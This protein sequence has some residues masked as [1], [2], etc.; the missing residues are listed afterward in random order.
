VGF[1]ESIHEKG[2]IPRDLRIP[3]IIERDGKLFIIDFG[4]A[5]YLNDEENDDPNDHP[6]KIRM[7]AVTIKSDLFALGHFALF[8][9]YSSYEP[10]TKHEGSWEEEL[11]ISQP[12]KSILRKLLQLDLPFSS[13][14]EVKSKLKSL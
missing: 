13:V 7:R 12:F 10:L 1:I 14:S 5:C 2:I 4:L 9:L 8:L 11:N 6:E 3:N